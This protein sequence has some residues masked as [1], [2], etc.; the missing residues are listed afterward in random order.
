LLE[1]NLSELKSLSDD[2]KAHVLKGLSALAKFLGIYEDFKAAVKNYGITWAGRSKDDIVIERMT[3]IQDPGEVYAWIREVKRAR[4][5][6]A[7]LMDLMAITGMRLVEAIDSYNLIVKLSRAGKLGEYYN[8]EKGILEHFKYKETF[9]R[10]TKKTFISFVP[11]DLVER[12]EGSKPI[13]SANS[14]LKMLQRS[15]IRC[16]FGDIRE[17]HATFLTKYLQQPEIDFLHGR[18][19]TNVFMRNYFNPA[20]IADLKTRAFQGIQEIEEKIA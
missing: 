6:I 15:G 4:P 10:N 19:S 9:I 13:P 1:N 8:A 20:L 11:K 3:K 7:D 16:R 14:I 5:E 2:K 12:I 17:A 18:V